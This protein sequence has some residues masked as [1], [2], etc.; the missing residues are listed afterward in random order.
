MIHA[1]TEKLKLKT[2]ALQRIFGKP[3]RKAML[4]FAASVKSSEDELYA[5]F[6]ALFNDEK[7]KVKTADALVPK[8]LESLEKE[9]NISK[10]DMEIAFLEKKK[11][12][13]CECSDGDGPRISPTIPVIPCSLPHSGFKGP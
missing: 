1:D 5:K 13:H 2:V 11:K 10:E 6:S 8:L 3:Y 9:K 4:A 12:I 7:E